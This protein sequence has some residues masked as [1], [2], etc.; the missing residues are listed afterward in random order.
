M[1]ARIPSAKDTRTADSSVSLQHRHFAFIAATIAD[2]PFNT[3][4]Q[5]ARAF[6]E[7]CKR[8]NP[9]FDRERFLAACRAESA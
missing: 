7:A 6:S 8:T 3:R 4:E 9:R 2:L 5:T 1:P